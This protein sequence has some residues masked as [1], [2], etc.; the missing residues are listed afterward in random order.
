MKEGG[1]TSFTGVP[2][3][4]EILSKLRF[5]RMNLPDLQIITQ[6]GGKLSKDC[7]KSAA[8]MPREQERNSSQLTARQNALHV[9]LILKLT[10]QARS[11]GALARQNQ[12]T[13]LNH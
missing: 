4:Y 2:F 3:S 9:W 8:T 12:R 5:F 7:S 11:R 10:W 6:G 1:V 13:A